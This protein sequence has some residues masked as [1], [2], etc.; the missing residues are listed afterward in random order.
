MSLRL[1][2]AIRFGGMLKPQC[3]GFFD[4][5]T[6]GVCALTGAYEASGQKLNLTKYGV[7]ARIMAYLEKNYPIL[8]KK[9][10]HPYLNL[11]DN[12]PYITKLTSIIY[13]LNDIKGFTRDQIADYVEYIENLDEISKQTKE[14]TIV[15]IK[16]QEYAII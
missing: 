14:E 13:Q 16:E 7:P 6:G 9:V 4:I 10:L 15:K 8:Q 11:D 2:E 3:I 1:S 5:E 12:K